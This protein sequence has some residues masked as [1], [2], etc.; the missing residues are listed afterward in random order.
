MYSLCSSNSGWWQTSPGQLMLPL[1]RI[2][3]IITH[4]R[5][6]FGQNTFPSKHIFGRRREIIM[7]F[8]WWRLDE[9]FDCLQGERW[10]DTNRLNQWREYT[11]TS[12]CCSNREGG[13]R[14]RRRLKQESVST[15]K[16]SLLTLVFLYLLLLFTS[17]P[18]VKLLQDDVLLIKKDQY[19]YTLYTIKFNI[20]T[21]KGHG[22]LSR[23]SQTTPNMFKSIKIKG[24]MLCIMFL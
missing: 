1:V 2:N 4:L 11:D 17:T 24:C 20:P 15:Q 5:N 23:I 12:S 18:N 8:C 6:I 10:W 22:L 21:Y 14:W 19:N 16:R 7:Y 9:W 13:K 3:H